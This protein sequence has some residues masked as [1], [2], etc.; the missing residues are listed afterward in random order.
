M[1][2]CATGW[3][4]SLFEIMLLGERTTTLA[5][6]FNVREGF[7]RKD[8]ELPDRL[9]EPLK[10]GPLTGVKLDRDQF[11]R[12]LDVYYEMMGWEGSNGMPKESKLQHLNFRCKWP[13]HF[14]PDRGPVRSVRS[15]GLEF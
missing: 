11:K 1:V 5:R 7:D 6:M 13:I 8:D 4:T 15:V 3:E 9:F 10:T 12:A 2:Q 14:P